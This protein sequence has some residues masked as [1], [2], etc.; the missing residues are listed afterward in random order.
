M[1]KIKALCVGASI[2][3]GILF[4]PNLNFSNIEKPTATIEVKAAT[5]YSVT[6]G[7][8]LQKAAKS[9]KKGDIIIVKGSIKSKEITLSSGVTLKG[10]KGK[11][12]FSSSSKGKPGIKI[13]GTGV[14]VQDLQIFNAKDN[15]ILITG[16]GNT[17]RNLNVHDCNDSGV[18]LSNGASN[19]YIKSVH[20]HHNADKSNG[21]E[22][23]DGFAIKLHSGIGNI[24]ENCIANNN[25]DD[26]FDCYSAHGA[27]TFKRCQANYNGNCYGVKGDGNG[28]KLGGVDNK[29]SGVKPHLDP[30]NHV[31]VN[32][33]A[34]GNTGSGFDRN[35]QNG[36]VTMTNCTGDS[37]K[38]YNYNWPSKGKPSALG[39]EV[40]FGRAKIVNSTSINGKNNIS[41]AD[42]I[43]K[44]NGF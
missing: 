38:K 27:I 23:A 31:L 39:Y 24:L 43:G 37:N 28:F 33:S 1:K 35:N 30:L 11:I 34:K 41:G 22:N 4:L 16:N 42:L 2:G 32:C 6:N 26:G 15:G 5:T 7:N 13:S 29:T 10:D 17:L 44:C 12:D 18:Q 19:N 36:I 40:T 9:A 21:G 25:S 3:L 20:S 8:D 14:T